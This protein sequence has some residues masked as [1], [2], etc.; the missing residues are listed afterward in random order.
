MHGSQ[1]SCGSQPA[2]SILQL[3]PERPSRH[4]QRCTRELLDLE[5]QSQASRNACQSATVLQE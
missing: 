4:A 2:G 3:W 1:E 5:G